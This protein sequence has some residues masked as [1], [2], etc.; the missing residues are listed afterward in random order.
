VINSEDCAQV[1]GSLF[2]Q[3]CIATGR[4]AL[5]AVLEP[6]G[7]C[8]G[9]ICMY[10]G[11]F[12]TPLGGV[13]MTQSIHVGILLSSTLVI[14]GLLVI[15]S[16]VSSLDST[17]SPSIEYSGITHIQRCHE[18]V[19]G[20]E[21]AE[22]TYSSYTGTAYYDSLKSNNLHKSHSRFDSNSIVKV[23]LRNYFGNAFIIPYPVI[24]EWKGR[25]KKVV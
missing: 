25:I 9:A 11:S 8:E 12:A 13:W 6:H 19:I 16:L 3:S 1:G 14:L 2:R 21:T 17:V 7:I 4:E 23:D 10:I 20:H 5:G 24:D 18:L 22:V 15:V